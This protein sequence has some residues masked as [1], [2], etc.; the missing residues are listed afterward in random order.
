MNSLLSYPLFF[1]GVRM[2]VLWFRP[3][4]RNAWLLAIMFSGFI[5]LA[6]F[7]NSETEPLVP[8]HYPSICTDFPVRVSGTVSCSLLLLLCRLSRPFPVGSQSRLA[9]ICIAWNNCSDRV[10]AGVDRSGNRVY[11]DDFPSR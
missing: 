9:E 1:L 11:G 6:P 4:D 8:S 2:A 7:V 10:T 5:A 3:L